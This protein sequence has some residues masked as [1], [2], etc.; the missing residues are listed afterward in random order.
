MPGWTKSSRHSCALLSPPERNNRAYFFL[1]PFFFQ[2]QYQWS[3]GLLIGFFAGLG[4]GRLCSASSCVAKRR[5]RRTW[6]PPPLSVKR[7]KNSP[8]EQRLISTLRMV[9]FDSMIYALSPTLMGMITSLLSYDISIA[10]FFGHDRVKAKTPDQFLAES[11][12]LFLGLEFFFLRKLIISPICWYSVLDSS[13]AFL[14][15]GSIFLS[16]SICSETFIVLNGIANFPLLLQTAQHSLK[17]FKIRIIL[18]R[19]VNCKLYG[20][21]GM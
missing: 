11:S 13:Q 17:H 21:E 14:K 16:N 19:T 3:Y 9:R 5:L 8:P 20:F 18:R 10:T 1:F 6:M 12:F 7:T 15:S 4:F 2:Y